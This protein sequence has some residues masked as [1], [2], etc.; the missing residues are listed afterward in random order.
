[1]LDLSVQPGAR[2]NGWNGRL[3]DRF[4]VQLTAPAIEGKANRALIS[5]LSDHFRVRRNQVQ[6]LRGEHTRHKQVRI[7]SPREGP[8]D[9]RKRTGP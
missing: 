1:M 3:G 2:R 8:S 4:K 7:L 9:L 6:L 5:F